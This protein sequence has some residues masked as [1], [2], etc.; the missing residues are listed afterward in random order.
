MGVEYGSPVKDVITGLT[1]QWLGWKSAYL[2]PEKES[3]CRRSAN[4]F[5]SYA[6][7]AEEMICGRFS[8]SVLRV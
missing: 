1:I 3:F 2:N 7:A 6:F 8:V 4:Q 5:A